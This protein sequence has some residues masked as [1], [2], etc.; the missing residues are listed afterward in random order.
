[1]SGYQGYALRHKVHWS[2]VLP[3]P[4]SSDHRYEKNI[5]IGSEVYIWRIQCYFAPMTTE[6]GE[7]LVGAYLQ[8]FCECDVIQYN[9]RRPGG[10]RVGQNE[11][12]VVGLNLKDRKAYLC[13]VA[14]HICGLLYGRGNNQTIERIKL[15]MKVHRDFAADR[16]PDFK[17]RFMFWSPVVMPGVLE[18]LK[19]MD[20]VELWVNGKYRTAVESL[21]NI[22][23]K[24][25]H[26]MGNPFMRTLQILEHLRAD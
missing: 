24:Q 9:V 7:Y 3:A 12:D 26:D 15:K 14:T 6:I 16:L 4:N 22:A 18:R 13:E 1:M 10:K 20:G 8:H 23:K 5:G 17:A 2:G 19:L 25:S 21:Q 11:L